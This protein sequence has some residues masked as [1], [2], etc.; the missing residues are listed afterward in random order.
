[1][2]SFIE[3]GKL[4]PWRVVEG[5]FGHPVGSRSTFFH[6]QREYNKQ[7]RYYLT[8][9]EPAPDAG[10][11]KDGQTGDA[12]KD[13]WARREAIKTLGDFGASYTPAVS[14]LIKVL[15]GQDVGLQREACRAIRF[16]GPRASA[17]REA[18][19]KLAKSTDLELNQEARWALRACAPSK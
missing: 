7:G 4:E 12:A 9:L 15:E 3:S 16:I 1:M 17:A 14:A 18:L 6:S 11:G 19:T 10:K 13:F 8:T 5:S 2:R